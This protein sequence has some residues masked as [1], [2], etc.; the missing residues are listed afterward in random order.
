MKI[1]R[2]ILYVHQIKIVHLVKVFTSTQTVETSTL[3]LSKALPTGTVKIKYMITQQVQPE[4]EKMETQV[5]SV[6]WCGE[7]LAAW[8]A[9][10]MANSWYVFIL[11]RGH[12]TFLKKKSK[13]MFSAPPKITQ[14]SY[15]QQGVMLSTIQIL[16]ASVMH[17]F[18]LEEPKQPMGN[19]SV[20][21]KLLIS[22]WDLLRNE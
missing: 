5:N 15:K 19:S 2:T 9:L 18:S 4:L 11:W 12:K 21:Q 10:L 8:D 6:G 20:K 17:A 14:V 16:V 22:K 3:N 7:I 1:E 13:I